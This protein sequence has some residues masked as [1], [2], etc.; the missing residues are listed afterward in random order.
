M[1]TRL[2]GVGRGRLGLWLA[3]ALAAVV[4]P[5][6][7]WAAGERAKVIMPDDI[8]TWTVDVFCHGGG[9]FVQGPKL[10]GAAAGKIVFDSKGNGFV[11][12]GT[13]IEM[14]TRDGAV[15]LLAGTPGIGGNTGGPA[16]KASFSGACDLALADDNTL[17][18]IDGINF[19]LRRLTRQADG[20]WSV[21]TVAGQPGK[22]GH[23]DGRGAEVLFDAPFDSMAISDDGVVY[24]LDHDWLRKFENGVVT[25]LNA[26]TGRADGPL[27]KAQFS[28][29]MGAGLGLSFDN[30][31]NLYVGDRWN[32]A[33]RKVNLKKGEVTTYAG[34][35][36]GASGGGPFDGP[37]FEGRFH[38]GGGPCSLVYNRKYNFLVA[39][40]ADEGALRYIKDGWIKT[41]GMQGKAYTGPLR[42]VSGGGPI[43]VD[44]DGN[45]YLGSREG[46]I[47]VIRKVAGK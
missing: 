1:L 16:W 20:S 22:L 46:G 40:A 31:G 42:S 35:L 38:P 24:T 14:V 43:G 47:R 33:I 19:T 32:M 30:E 6:A 8:D 44:K 28:R 41:F 12:C 36:P 25:T 7:L 3:A 37:E 34:K 45:I 27:E 9:S 18:V 4:V 5:A 23:H 13:F 26:G 21:E 11:A 10:E 17:Y 2:R 39:I 29:I 15:R